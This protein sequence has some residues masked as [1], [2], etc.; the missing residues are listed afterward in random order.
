MGND[1][2]N[3]AGK[4]QTVFRCG[5]KDEERAVITPQSMCCAPINKLCRKYTIGSC[6]AH[7]PPGRPEGSQAPLRS[8][9]AGSPQPVLLQ[10]AAPPQGQEWDLPMFNFIR[11]PLACFP[12]PSGLL[13][14]AALPSWESTGPPQFGVFCTAEE[15]ALCHL[16]Q[17]TDK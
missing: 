10:G 2:L 16:L 13:L 8:R 3:S 6:S 11:L 12:S 5:F 15:S 4:L 14:V 9:A 7:C 1:G 17:A